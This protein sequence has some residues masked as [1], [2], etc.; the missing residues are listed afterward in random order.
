MG[1]KESAQSTAS[2]KSTAM[3]YSQTR[4]V[5]PKS[6]KMVERLNDTL[7]DYCGKRLVE[8]YSARNLCK[9]VLGQ[10]TGL[11]HL[12]KSMGATVRGHRSNR[13]S[14]PNCRNVLGFVKREKVLDSRIPIRSIHPHKW[15]ATTKASGA[16]Q[17]KRLW[18]LI[19]I[20]LYKVRHSNK[21]EPN[22]CRCLKTRAQATK[23]RCGTGQLG[24]LAALVAGP[25]GLLLEVSGHA[26][27]TSGFDWWSTR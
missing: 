12:N 18:P 3:A 9:I 13:R 2:N 15:M 1:K 14:Q 16:I 11:L 6:T 20:S 10:Q 17:L 23:V 4:L 26:G 7:T 22:T 24:R 19:A 25:V 5:C 8:L 27:R 21:T